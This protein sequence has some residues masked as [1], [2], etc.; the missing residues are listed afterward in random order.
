MLFEIVYCFEILLFLLYFGPNKGWLGEQER[1][2]F[3][4][5]KKSSK[6]FDW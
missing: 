1:V 5:H 2:F 3:K 6:T 4:K